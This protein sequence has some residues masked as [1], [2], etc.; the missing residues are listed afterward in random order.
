MMQ[1]Q[2]LNSVNLHENIKNSSLEANDQNLDILRFDHSNL[3]FDQCGIESFDESIDRQRVIDELR[4]MLGELQESN[5]SL[6]KE[7]LY[8]QKKLELSKEANI[9][10]NKDDA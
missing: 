6:L 3:N 10:L 1:R 4:L 8:L 2:T 7:K 9:H 5:Q